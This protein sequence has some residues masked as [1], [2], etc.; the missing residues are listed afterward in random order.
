M[1]KNYNNADTGKN[2]GKRGKG[3][4]FGTN[5]VF[6]LKVK[7]CVQDIST[8][9]PFDPYVLLVQHFKL[10]SAVGSVSQI[11]KTV[12]FQQFLPVQ[13]KAFV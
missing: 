2:C 3:S 13:S 4:E 10:F 9:S 5:E 7:N 8:I 12:C 11:N 1:N 6:I